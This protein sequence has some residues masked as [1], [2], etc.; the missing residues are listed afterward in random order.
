MLIGLAL[1]AGAATAFARQPREPINYLGDRKI[2]RLVPAKIASWEFLTTSGLVVPTEDALSAALYSQLLTRVYVNGKDPPIMLLVAQSAGQSGIL[3]IHRPEF[4]YP[5]GGFELS[6]IVPANLPVGTSSIRMNE[7]TATLPGRT[8]QIIYWTR[9]GGR[10]PV[11]WAEQR[12]AVASDNLRGYIP[13]AV[14]T[15]ISTVDSDRS[16][17]FDRMA[18]FA[19]AMLAALG[20]NRNVLVTA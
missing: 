7:L 11:S 14:L 17:A 18:D 15:R 13:D 5:A 8:E 9:V 16:A 4:C 6:P 20:A 10:M 1:A 12:L 3:Q 2:E 19:E